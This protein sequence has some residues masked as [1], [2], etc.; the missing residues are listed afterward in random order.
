MTSSRQ[1]ILVLLVAR[2]IVLDQSR[3]RRHRLL[4]CVH[5]PLVP[6]V[7]PVFPCSPPSPI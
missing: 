1:L 6:P 7:H 5:L 2:G 4:P 3:R